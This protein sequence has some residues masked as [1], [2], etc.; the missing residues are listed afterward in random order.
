MPHLGQRGYKLNSYN[1]LKVLSMQTFKYAT[2]GNFWRC[3]KAS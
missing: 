2:F 3:K 1:Y